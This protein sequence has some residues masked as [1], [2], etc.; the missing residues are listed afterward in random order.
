MKLVDLTVKDFLK[1]VDSNSPA[2]GGGSVSALSSSLGCA[3]SRMVAHLTFGKKAYKALSEE[4]VALFHKAFDELEICKNRLEEL[5]DKDTEAYNL[6]MGAYKLSKETEEEKAHRNK[7]IQDN[8]KLAVETPF[9]IC[10]YSREAMRCVET[11]LKYGNKNAITD[12][13]VGAIL[14]FSG[15]EG[16]ILNVKINLLSIEDKEFVENISKELDEIYSEC[17]EYRERILEAVNKSF[18]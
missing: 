17:R 1:E 12:V 11:I 10:K 14:L 5:I 9:G 3:L 6:V 7:V 16:G 13:G 4:E 18:L 8:L 2:P 15:V